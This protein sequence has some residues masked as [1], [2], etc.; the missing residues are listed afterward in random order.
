MIIK[1]AL[2]DRLSLQSIQSRCARKKLKQNIP[3]TTDTIQNTTI[4]FLPE[5]EQQQ[6][7][8]YKKIPPEKMV[9]FRLFTRIISEMLLFSFLRY[10]P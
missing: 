10:K 5:Q 6:K 4:F 2:G 3:T 1:Y 9:Q 8:G 7:S